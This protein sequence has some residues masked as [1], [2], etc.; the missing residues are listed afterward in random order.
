MSYD[1]LDVRPLTQ[2]IG[3]EIAGVDLTKPLTNRQTAEL[4]D[5]IADHQVIFF[6]DQHLDHESHL[7][8]GRLFGDL[9]LHSAVDGLADYPEIIEI[10]ADATSKYIAGEDWHSDL[11]CDPVPPMGSI[12]YLH[13]V[14]ETGGDTMFASMY[15]AYE[16]LSPRMQSYL[17]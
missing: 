16:A 6:R 12:L 4:K 7:R 11:T 15:A 5:A 14:P 17:E 9:A 2:R 13:T 3:A 1:V 8:F 10:H